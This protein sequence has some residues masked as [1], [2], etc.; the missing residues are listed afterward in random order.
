MPAP[1]VAAAAKFATKE[2]LRQVNKRFPGGL[3]GAG[4]A[5]VMAG[6]LAFGVLITTIFSAMTT[7]VMAT[8]NECGAQSGSQTASPAALAGIPQVALDAY[9]KA[10]KTTGV[11]WIYLAALGKIESGHGSANGATLG[12]DG[13]ASPMIK[14]PPLNGSGFGGNNKP[15]PYN[16]P[17]AIDGWDHGVGPMQF[18][19]STWYGGAGKDGNTDGK[20]DP[21]NIWDA[22]L[23]SGF[24]LKAH[25]APANMDSA[26][27]A[28]NRSSAYVAK[29][30]AAAQEY[31]AAA[32]KEGTVADVVPAADVAP[33][34]KFDQPVE[35]GKY[36]L[37][38]QFGSASTGQ[39]YLTDPGVTVEA[40]ADGK[41]TAVTGSTITFDHGKVDG[42]AIAVTL[43]GVTK[44]VVK[45]G[46]AV[47]SGDPVATT[48]G[49]G[50]TLEL[51]A[52]G[53]LVDPV[54]FFVEAG[55]VAPGDEG[56]CG[57][58]LAVSVGD[59]DSA[60]AGPWGGHSNGRI[61]AAAL[62][63]IPWQP[64]DSMRCDA[65]KSLVALNAA[66]KAK[67]GHNICV[68][69]GYRSY[70]KQ[71]YLYAT[72]PRGVAAVPG[73]SNH[74]WGMAIDL[75]CGVGI[76]GNAKHN[77]MAANGPTYGY[78]QPSWAKQGSSRAEAW[79]WQFGKVS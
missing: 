53:T 28:Y 2:G 52:S 8:Q 34:P 48:A 4:F 40:V 15:L 59:F 32:E 74:G 33:A 76:F 57:G 71:V 23:A 17:G 6:L 20:N 55:G 37:G 65:T 47:S 56:G 46:Q 66:Y 77:W 54:T 79:H 14:T 78:A 58:G 63:P 44:P 38:A 51:R 75:G 31:K 73:T 26:I 70:E 49:T 45:A 39:R 69:E 12:T 7:T 22:A 61:P 9:Q 11:D 19:L 42:K 36:A 50:F 10:G 1:I 30:K 67:W 72:K 29:V 64:V 16:G 43:V 18:L 41:V 62:C 35:A 25:G 27:F 13:V 60:V 68:N 5:A 24:Y 21:N 3:L